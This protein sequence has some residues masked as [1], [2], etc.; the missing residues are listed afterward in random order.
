MRIISTIKASCRDC[1][2]CVRY[3]PV[4]AIKVTDGH[5]EVI[6]DRCI[7]DGRCVTICPQNAKK[8]LEDKGK[9][10][11][12]ISKKE[13]IAISL[14]PSFVAL[15]EFTDSRQFIGTLHTMG[16]TYVAE[17]AEGAEIVAKEH[18]RLISKDTPLITSCCPAIVN[19]I[20]IYYPHLLPYLAPVVSPMVAH[21]RILK[22]RY[23]SEIK[24]V[25]PN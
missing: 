6:E 1:Y 2:K 16:F 5:A 3:C 7:A 11:G 21:G 4:K 18:L 8:V 20:E 22:Q 14:A 23:G 12:F 24:V 19:L 25:E 9:V 15:E 13:K 17:T 10:Q